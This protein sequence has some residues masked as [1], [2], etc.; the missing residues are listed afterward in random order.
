LRPPVTRPG[1]LRVAL[2]WVAR[3]AVL[4]TVLLAV[5][6]AVA[7]SVEAMSTWWLELL[8]YV[9][10]PVYLLPA[11]AA[12]ALSS[13]LTR[14]WRLAAGLGAA[15]VATVV[16]G[17]VWGRADTGAEPLRMMT[18]NIK[19]YLAGP[20]AEAFDGIAHEVAQHNPDILVMQDA[21][22]LAERR[23]RS[24][25]LLAGLF[26]GRSVYAHGQ[27]I[28]ISRFPLHDCRPGDIA[29]RGNRFD[30]ARCVVTVRGHDIDLLT[31]H[32][33]S[34]RRGLNATRRE[35]VEGLD[36]WQQNFA[37]RLVQAG[38]LAVD[39]GARTRPL[40]LA[41]DLNASQASPV[42]RR[43]LARGLRD[44]FA[45]AGW[46]YGYTHGHAL[47][48]GVSFLR[49]DHILVSDEIGIVD[50]F[51]GGWQASEHRPVIADL[52]L[53]RSSR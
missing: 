29:F 5:S 38:K 31:A 15:L 8:Q 45:S 2:Q 14:A 3:L 10:Y 53:Q 13:L 43:L 34:P 46:G 7:Y 25:A 48:V 27:Y 39:V 12:V 16:M 50:A 11:L 18:Y 35:P 26:A 22:E 32:L 4:A 19:S 1:R 23:Q 51:P 40:I 42:I 37:D 47:R 52:L 36:D 33:L 9:P 24:P 17:F 44:A 49:I 6:Q 28:I 30:Y 21:G 41:G 20:G